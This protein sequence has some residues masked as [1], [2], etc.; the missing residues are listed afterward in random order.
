MV[1][2]I[3]KKFFLKIAIK[4]GKFTFSPSSTYAIFGSRLTFSKESTTS[5][6]DS[7]DKKAISCEK[8]FV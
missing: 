7:L 5:R 3:E 4:Y 8:E 6:K 1:V 2:E